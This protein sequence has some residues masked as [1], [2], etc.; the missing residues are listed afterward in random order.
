MAAESF[1]TSTGST[2]G[3]ATAGSF[4]TSIGVAG[5]STHDSTTRSTVESWF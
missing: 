3:K 4:D 2:S 5:T 1:D